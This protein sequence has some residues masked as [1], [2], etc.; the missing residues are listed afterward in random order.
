MNMD[1]GRY[2]GFIGDA[3]TL[4]NTDDEPQEVTRAASDV[5]KALEG[6][7]SRIA[8]DIEFTEHGVEM[9]SALELAD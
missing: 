2:Y 6:L 5:M 9:P 8:F 4:R 1:A 7:F 3:M